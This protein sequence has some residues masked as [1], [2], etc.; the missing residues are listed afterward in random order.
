MRIAPGGE[1]QAESDDERSARLRAAE[2]VHA[3][4]A[5]AAATSFAPLVR[6]GT[7]ILKAVALLNGGAAAATVF[8]IGA[9]LSD[10]P[11][12]ARALV[13]SVAAFGFGL[14][15]AAF[16]TGWSYL[17]YSGHADA[18]ARVTYVWRPPFVEESPASTRA[19]RRGDLFANLAFVA[20]MVSMASAVGGFA[21]AGFALLQIGP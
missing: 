16:A 20:V 5:G 10:K 4:H 14:S 19:R 18:L 12:L 2:R 9:G 3:V 17:S 8:V 11:G 1:S 13:P 21:M 15:V 7:D 6:M